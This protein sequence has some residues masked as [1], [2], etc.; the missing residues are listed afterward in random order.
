MEIAVAGLSDMEELLNEIKNK[1][2]VD[3]MREAIACYNGGAYRGCI[4]LSYIALF[5]D[6][7]GKLAELGKVN[8]DA[9]KIW[10]EVEKRANDQQVFETYM[11]DQLKAK[12]LLEEKKYQRLNMVRDLR[13]KAAHPSGLHASAEEARFV[14]KTVI[15]EFLRE[16][17]LK[18]T[19]AVDSIIE[20]LAKG[21]FFPTNKMEDVAEIVKDEL[22]K[23][24]EK[25]YPYL[26]GELVKAHATAATSN[27]AE[28]FLVGMASLEVEER[29]ELLRKKVITPS[30]VDDGSAAFIGR[31]ISADAKLLDGLSAA[32]HVRIC[33]LLAE[34]T[35]TSA[36]GLVS[37]YTHPARQ[38]SSMAVK[39]PEEKILGEYQDFFSEVLKKYP[40]EALLANSFKGKA[41]LAEK[42]IDSWKKSAGSSTYDVANKFAQSIQEVDSVVT[43]LLDDEDA[44]E[45]VVAVKTAADWGAFTSKALIKSKF[46][47]APN[48]ASAARKYAKDNPK[49]AE[50]I[51]VEKELAKN[52]EEFVLEVL[53][54]ETAATES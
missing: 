18:T 19:H 25:V 31:M 34:Q 36:V 32:D 11:A 9:K 21:N 4:V 16:G 51:V 52:I 2:F 46:S 40:Y 23:L 6:L 44:F 43:G 48:I 5:D 29:R 7:R 41:K 10:T 37:K 15:Q 12:G 13:N 1:D 42:L 49:K 38:L 30:C 24:H 45:V 8:S 35:K 26:V 17:L 3:Y 14:F 33:K 28:R 27:N 50:S 54:S 20:N 39:L 47:D 22:S 53:T